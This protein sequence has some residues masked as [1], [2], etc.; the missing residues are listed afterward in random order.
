MD[1]CFDIA[2]INETIV[3]MIDYHILVCNLEGQIVFSNKV[4]QAYLGYSDLELKQKSFLSVIGDIQINK[5]KSI[6]ANVSQ[7]PSKWG[8]LMFNGK[9]HKFKLHVKFFQKRNLIYIYGN[10]KYVEYER[11]RKN[12][13]LKLQMP[14]RFTKNLF[15]IVFL[16]QRVFLFLIFIFQHKN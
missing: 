15:Q 4:M 16:I 10:E 14:L 3:D 2:K 5:A 6:I 12:W 1:K 7:K 8:E 11:I 9:H 13:I